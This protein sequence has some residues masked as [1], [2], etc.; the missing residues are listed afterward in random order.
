MYAW[1]V[2]HHSHLQ[3]F[4]C[5]MAMQMPTPCGLPACRQPWGF[6][7]SWWVRGSSSPIWYGIKGFDDL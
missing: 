1:C 6:P 5:Q 3:I 4:H 2:I 7:R